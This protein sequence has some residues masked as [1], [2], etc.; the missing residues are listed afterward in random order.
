M[1]TCVTVIKVDTYIT[2]GD[3]QYR[4]V[5][6]WFHLEIVNSLVYFFSALSPAFLMTCKPP[7]YMGPE[8]IKYFS[9]T[10]IDVSVTLQTMLVAVVYLYI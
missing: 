3:S 4:F 10:T 5:L 1:F 8:Y 9:D 2:I 7:L 6:A